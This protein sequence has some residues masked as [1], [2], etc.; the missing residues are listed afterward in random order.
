M[1]RDCRGTPTDRFNKFK[2]AL[3]IEDEAELIEQLETLVIDGVDLDGVDLANGE[4]GQEEQM[5]PVEG[6]CE[7]T[8]GAVVYAD[9]YSEN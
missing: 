2:T 1:A 8:N 3:C 5:E 7:D 6:A 4:E 9:G